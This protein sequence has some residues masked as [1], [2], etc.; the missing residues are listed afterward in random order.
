MTAREGWSV[1]TARAN[2]SVLVPLPEGL[3]FDT[4]AG[5]VTITVTTISVTARMFV[6]AGPVLSRGHRSA[7][8]EASVTTEPGY[9]PAGASDAAMTYA[10]RLRALVVTTGDDLAARAARI[11][12]AV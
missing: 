3:W 4:R 9:R 7:V 10:G 1:T 2:V 5:D 11:A 8:E 12:A 6:W